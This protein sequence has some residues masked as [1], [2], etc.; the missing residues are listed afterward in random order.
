MAE[1]KNKRTRLNIS[2]P[3]V[4]STMNGQCPSIPQTED[5]PLKDKHSLSIKPEIEFPILEHAAKNLIESLSNGVW[6]EFKQTPYQEMILMHG[7]KEA[8]LRSVFESIPQEIL[9]LQG[10]VLTL[11]KLNQIREK[12]GPSDAWPDN[13]G[14]CDIV[15]DIRDPT[16]WRPYVGQSKCV[17]SLPSM[18]MEDFMDLDA[19]T[20][21]LNVLPPLFDGINVAKEVRNR[22]QEELRDSPDP[23][24]RGYPDVRESQSHFRAMAVKKNAC[25]APS[26]TTDQYRSEVVQALLKY[27][28]RLTFHMLGLKTNTNDNKDFDIAAHVQET[29]VDLDLSSDAEPLI[30]P[31]ERFELIY[32]ATLIVKQTFTEEEVARSKELYTQ[33]T[34]YSYPKFEAGVNSKTRVDVGRTSRTSPPANAD[35]SSEMKKQSSAVEKPVPGDDYIDE[36]EFQEILNAADPL[37]APEATDEDFTEEFERKSQ[38][39]QCWA[40][41]TDS[42]RQSLLIGRLYDGHPRR[43]EHHY[44][45]HHSHFEIRFRRENLDLKWK[46]LVT[47]QLSPYGTRHPHCYAWQAQEIDPA[48]RIAVLIQGKLLNGEEF[49][50]L[51][52]DQEK[53]WQ[54]EKKARS[55]IRERNQW[56]EKFKSPDE[57]QESTL[58]LVL[59]TSLSKSPQPASAT[60]TANY[61]G[62]IY[63]F[64]FANHTPSHGTVGIIVSLGSSVTIKWHVGRRVDVNLLKHQ[65]H[66]CPPCKIGN[67]IRYRQSKE[68]ASLSHDSG[69]SEYILRDPETL[70][71]LPDQVTFDQAA[72]LM[73]AGATVWAAIEE[74]EAQVEAP[75][76]IIR[77][78]GLGSLAIQ[79]AKVL[80][81][82]VVA[83]DNLP[84]GRAL[85]TEGPFQADLVLDIFN[86]SK[87]PKQV[88]AWSSDV[89]LAAV[90]VCTDDTD[91]IE[92]SLKTLRPHGVCVALGVPEIGFKFND[93]DAVFACLKF[94]GSLVATPRQ[95]EDMLKA[96]AKFGIK[97][98]IT[99]RP[100]EK[101]PDVTNMYKDSGLKGRLVMAIDA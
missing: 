43:A 53:T 5:I 18:A 52:P 65:C 98:H 95:M 49:D 59:M 64:S 11:E 46:L 82:P 63:G 48:S 10:E 15:T 99:L 91:V 51:T 14:Y 67:N 70:V 24:I 66:S 22:Y 57:I 9:E 88:K 6:N 83:V 81:H 29:A 34:G 38:I 36:D 21:G 50:L 61:G 16:F 89:G 72:P 27:D 93:F 40:Y 42:T 92:W 75:L 20:I 90:I 2:V 45:I 12:Q 8:V 84:E 62:K 4:T 30:T 13:S 17:R 74:A 79:F 26:W 32:V 19:D 41:T 58:L 33:T 77:I 37:D 47:L 71:E 44:T 101:V 23:Y 96:V 73:C 100:L 68:I 25:V 55:K 3:G 54:E 80:G 31:F 1:P 56:K 28:P 69:M 39:P 60:P 94:K 7:G 35:R 87:T 86:P 78:A 85:A 76:G 97:S